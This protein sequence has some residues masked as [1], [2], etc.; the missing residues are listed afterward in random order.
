MVDLK[1][2]NVDFKEIEDKNY[3]KLVI[4]VQAILED[5]NKRVSKRASFFKKTGVINIGY[6]KVTKLIEVITFIKKDYYDLLIAYSVDFNCLIQTKLIE[7]EGSRSD[8][9]IISQSTTRLTRNN[10]EIYYKTKA[11]IVQVYEYNIQETI[12]NLYKHKYRELLNVKIDAYLFG[13]TSEISIYAREQGFKMLALLS[14]ERFTNYDL[15]AVKLNLLTNTFN[16]EQP[17]YFKEFK[18]FELIGIYKDCI[19]MEDLTEND[20]IEMSLDR[21]N[22]QQENFCQLLNSLLEN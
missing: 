14:K 3:G 1:V 16:I 22:G 15:P 4:N 5:T 17:D 21:V 2:L 7:Y 20:I 13:L 8:N 10:N 12:A 11:E 19:K 9:N 6:E 18:G